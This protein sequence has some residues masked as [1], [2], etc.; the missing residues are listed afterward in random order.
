MMKAKTLGK[1]LAMMLVAVMVVAMVPMAAF[2]ASFE[3]TFDANGGAAD[4]AT[5]TT[6][7][8]GKLSALP[9]ATREGYTFDGW[10]DGATQV[11]T[12]TVFTADTTVTAQWTE[13][14]APTTYTVTFHANGAVGEAVAQTFTEGT[15]Q[16]LAANTYSRDGYTFSGWATSAGGS[17][18]YGDGAS[19]TATADID[20]YAVWTETPAPETPV[21]TGYTITF[22][23]NGGSASAS[24]LN[25]DASSNKLTA[26]PT[27]TREGYNFS[28][29]YT[30]A[31]N[32]TKVTT[33]TVF[34]A[35]TTVYAHWSTHVHNAVYVA[36]KNPTTEESGR[37]GYY[38]CAECEKAFRDSDL[39]EEIPMSATVIAPLTK[40]QF[41]KGAGSTY[42]KS[43][44]GDLSFTT[45]GTVTRLYY[46]AVDGNVV[47]SS[48]Y[49]LASG[50]TVITLKNAYLKT[51]TVGQHTLTVVY[52]DN[53]GNIEGSAQTYFIVKGTGSTT[54]S[55]VKTSDDSNMILWISLA[56]VS[57]CGMGVTAAYGIKYAAGKKR[58][59]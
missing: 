11:T 1:L 31:T 26:M 49:S 13:I 48:Y 57:A 53:A 58:S 8:E 19:Y 3:I 5:A 59:R 37:I 56:V 22:N 38:Y 30:A 34:T 42:S 29:W 10:F 54:S 6:D 52:D 16:A 2:A 17:V 50:S 55:S 23:A 12:D 40:F 44:G 18:A 20:L 14:P 25:A 9:S 7:D 43:A 28:G 45:A 36:A 35:D 47:D 24:T 39:K 51:L 27:A 32:G 4:S 15:A 21:A 33:N 46:V 41:T